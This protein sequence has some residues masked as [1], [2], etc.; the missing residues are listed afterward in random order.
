MPKSSV[1]SILDTAASPL[2]YGYRTKITPHFDA[3]FRISR[4]S[5]GKQPEQNGEILGPVEVDIGFNRVGRREVMDIEVRLTLNYR[6]LKCLTS[7]VEKGMSY[8]DL[9]NQR[10]VTTTTRKYQEVIILL[11]SLMQS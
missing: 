11:A 10:H 5:R 6:A 1:P 4:R 3:P 9:R 8:S 7:G 2:Q